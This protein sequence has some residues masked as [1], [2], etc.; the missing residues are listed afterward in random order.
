[1]FRL[2]RFTCRFAQAS[3]RIHELLPAAASMLT[4]AKDKRAQEQLGLPSR[5]SVQRW[6]T[7]RVLAGRRPSAALPKAV[8]VAAEA[9]GKTEALIQAC[10]S[11]MAAL[12]T[13]HRLGQEARSEAAAHVANGPTRR[14]HRSKA[15][16]E[17][18]K[19]LLRPSRTYQCVLIESLVWSNGGSL[20]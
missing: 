1:M 13:T 15:S 6:V 11:R 5:S 14:S 10:D 3:S 16:H 18:P 20:A 8:L 2:G 9:Q 7:C 12:D 17:A 19:A 4:G